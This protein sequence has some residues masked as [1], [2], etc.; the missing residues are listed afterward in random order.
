LKA[1]KRDPAIAFL[2]GPGFWREARACSACIGKGDLKVQGNSSLGLIKHVAT[3]RHKEACNKLLAGG[4]APQGVR[5]GVGAVGAAEPG[6][7]EGM[8]VGPLVE[9]EPAGGQESAG[10]GD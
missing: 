4:G 3:D 5:K 10:L 2:T 8:V 9:D 6:L 7:E 1:V